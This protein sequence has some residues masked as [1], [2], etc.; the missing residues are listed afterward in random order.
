MPIFWTPIFIL[1]LYTK[2]PIMN[3][4]RWS[5]YKNNFFIIFVIFTSPKFN[6]FRNYFFCISFF[7]FCKINFSR[8]RFKF[9]PNIIWIRSFLIINIRPIIFIIINNMNRFVFLQISAI[10]YIW[11]IVINW[12][13]VG[14]LIFCLS[15]YNLSIL[16]LFF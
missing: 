1:M 2:L 5:F 15:N 11:V 13:M 8:I 4:S 14:A 6:C 12:W 3:F 7:F 10:W 9:S 16:K